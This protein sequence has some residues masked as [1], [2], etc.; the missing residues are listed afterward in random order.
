V[1]SHVTDTVRKGIIDP[2]FFAGWGAMSRTR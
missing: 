1:G 2:L